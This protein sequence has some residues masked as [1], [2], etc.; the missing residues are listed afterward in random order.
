MQSIEEK[1]IEFFLKD[2][3]KFSKEEGGKKEL[4]F[5]IQ[6][7]DGDI[8]D[9]KLKRFMGC[10]EESSVEQIVQF[11]DNHYNSEKT[12]SKKRKAIIQGLVKL[13]PLS[14]PLVLHYLHHFRMEDTGSMQGFDYSQCV[15]KEVG[16]ILN[17][18]KSAAGGVSSNLQDYEADLH[19]KEEEIRELEEDKRNKE[20]ILEKIEDIKKKDNEIT[21]LK[22]EIDDL[23]KEKAQDSRE[24]KIAELKKEKADKEKEK[25]V[26]NSKINELR[27][28][29][30]GLEKQYERNENFLKNIRKFLKYLPVDGED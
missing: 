1:D 2:V 19:K 17:G 11:I 30:D 12:D 16:A 18:F 27:E 7:M 14:R 29:I 5:F 15:L 23:D 26:E 13:Y 20:K 24:K 8:N 4:L 9:D 10:L 25:K 22:Q 3:E 21:R 6:G 28:S